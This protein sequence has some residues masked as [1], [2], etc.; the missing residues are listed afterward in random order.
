MGICRAT[1]AGRAA[2]VAAARSFVGVRFRPQGRARS[3]LDCLGLVL[4][5]AGASGLWLEAPAG[6]GLRRNDRTEIER[7]L[8]GLGAAP[9]PEGCP[10]EGVVEISEPVPGQVH[11]ALLRAGTVIEADAAIGRVV[12]RP[13][14]E[15]RIVRSRW[16]LPL[17]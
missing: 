2:F 3:G 10:A 16:I 14:G 7:R 5:S 15:A 12:E 1:R 9:V 11:F 6:Y 17:R 4:A 8:A 13:Q